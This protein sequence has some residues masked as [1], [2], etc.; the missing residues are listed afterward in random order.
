[1]SNVILDSGIYIA[2]VFQESLSAQAQ[3]LLHYFEQQQTTLHAPTLLR[4]EL[5]AVCRKAVFRQR[6]SPEDGEAIRDKLLRYPVTLHFDEELLTR[7]YEL[8]TQFNLPTA[9]D[10]QY[11]ALA[12]RI[13]CEFWTTDERL[14][15]TVN[16]SLPHVRWLGNGSSSIS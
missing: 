10:A 11:L 3:N 9:Y 12:E 14:F 1:M 6:V 2:S 8:A 7:G 4:Y 13:S 15:N 5:V 16:P